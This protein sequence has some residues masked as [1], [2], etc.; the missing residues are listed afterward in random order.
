M[1]LPHLCLALLL[2]TAPN[3]H[4]APPIRYKVIIDQVKKFLKY[5][6]VEAGREFVDKSTE[7]ADFILDLRYKIAMNEPIV[8]SESKLSAFIKEHF[9]DLGPYVSLESRLEAVRKRFRDIDLSAVHAISFETTSIDAFRDLEDHILNEEIMSRVAELENLRIVAEHLQELQLETE[10][11]LKDLDIV[12]RLMRAAANALA[13]VAKKRPDLSFLA[14]L[15]DTYL[16]N[17][18]YD[19]EISYPRLTAD[20][21]TEIQNKQK[22]I[23]LLLSDKL[24]PGYIQYGTG[25]QEL[26]KLQ[27]A[28]IKKR[29][30]E[31]DR[32]KRELEKK[33][34]ELKAWQQQ[35]T[36]DSSRIEN[37]NKTIQ[38]ANTD[39]PA[40]QNTI[41][42]QSRRISTNNK[43]I[44]LLN[45]PGYNDKNFRDCPNGATYSECN[46]P[47]LKAEFDRKKQDRIQSLQRD[48][49]QAQ[50]ILQQSGQ[51]I[52][53]LEQQRSQAQ[54]ENNQMIPAL[55]QSKAA[56]A[57][58]LTAFQK[59]A[60]AFLRSLMN[61]FILHF[62][63]T[64]AFANAQTTFFLQFAN[65]L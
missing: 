54:Q 13:D 33:D 40:L 57:A 41:H 15:F 8:R 64:N 29:K 35:I 60:A 1:K 58:E 55:Q 47:G 37:N 3:I 12:G 18:W 42:A 27:Q 28:N 24:K 32:Q 51:R 9:E 7:T 17:V 44:A 65:S 53:A 61:E 59:K 6:A 46:H 38:R 50:S 5:P 10:A 19:F 20:C 36:Q 48:N 21:R 62:V 4:A 52:T 34:A 22:E 14:N 2:F 31:F 11:S 39:I 49:N 30:D 45:D 16:F 56:Y 43:A 23:R 63:E 26:V 25:L